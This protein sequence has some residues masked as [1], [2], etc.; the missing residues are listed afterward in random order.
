MVALACWVYRE[1][2]REDATL[3]EEERNERR[4]D[5]QW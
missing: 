4:R 2:Q 3:T 1:G 5:N